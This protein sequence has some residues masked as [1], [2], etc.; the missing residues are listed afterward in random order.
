MDQT[1]PDI[2]LALIARDEETHIE[3]CLKSASG[4]AAE[5]IVVDTGSNDRTKEI[6]ITCG[7]RVLDFPWIDDFSAARNEALEA[8]RGRWILVLDADEYLPPASVEAIRALTSSAD[9]ADRA[10]HLVNKSSTDE[11]RT[12]ISGLIVRLFPNDPH[13]RYEWPVHEQVV[14]SLQRANIPIENTGIEI[15]HTGYS[16]PEVN[17]AKQQR[18]L[19][20]LEKMT[21]QAE[22]AH[23]MAWFLKGGA[24]LDLERTDEALAAYSQCTGMTNSGDSIHE[25]A[26][27]RW[28]SCLASLKRF[29]EI[30]EIHPTNQEAD[31]HPERLLL[32]G[33][34]EIA[35]VHRLTLGKFRSRTSCCYA[36]TGFA[37]DSNRARNQSIRGLGSRRNLTNSC[38]KS[39]TLCFVILGRVQDRCDPLHGGC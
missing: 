33:Q 13:V 28:A 10:Y 24:L 37:I 32:R 26:L 11:G 19:R 39:E 35:L 17:A 31:W 5:M 21:T 25:A 15:I 34:T 23:P 4:L 22:G 6:A 8:A 12:G 16:S 38:T 20:I 3:R 14:T 2:S 27:V 1:P 18:N 30:R 29:D 36:S 7:A 9:A